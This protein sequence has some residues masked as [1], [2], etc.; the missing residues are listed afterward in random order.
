MFTHPVSSGRN[1]FRVEFNEYAER[2]FRKR[3]AKDYKGRQWEMTERAILDDLAHLGHG[4]YALQKTQ[5]VDELWHEGD[6]W[7][8]K[9]DFRVA[10]TS[11]STKKSGNRVVAVLDAATGE[12]EIVLMYGKTDLPKNIGETQYIKRVVNEVRPD[13]GW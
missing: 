1:L 6:L 10:Q 9:Y 4:E 5:Q 13:V 7:V 3:F 2:H 8:F 12:I 11:V